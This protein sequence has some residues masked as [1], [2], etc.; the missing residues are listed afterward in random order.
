M[1]KS[2][3]EESGENFF[4]AGSGLLWPMIGLALIA[5]NISTEQIV[6]MTGQ[7][8]S[9]VGLAIASYEWTAAFVSVGW[10]VS[11]KSSMG[12]KPHFILSFPAATRRCKVSKTMNRPT[13]RTGGINNNLPQCCL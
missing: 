10:A 8:A 5:A 11:S 1:Y 6:G 7:G 4:V 2:R 9:S 12:M 13:L 3:K